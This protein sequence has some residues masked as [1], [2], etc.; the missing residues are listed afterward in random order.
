M[1]S[2]Y[3]LDIWSIRIEA[4]LGSMLISINLP[5]GQIACAESFVRPKE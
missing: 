2:K 5:V 4:R 3:R 1:G